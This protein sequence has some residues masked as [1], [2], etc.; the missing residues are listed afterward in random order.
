[1][2]HKLENGRIMMRQSRHDAMNDIRKV[3]EISDDEKER[4]EKEV[5]KVIDE[6]S[7]LI[8]SLGKQK[9]EELLQ[10]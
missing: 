10:I 4:L 7:S 8:D 9:E 1:M 3:E 6:T 5:Q 2:K